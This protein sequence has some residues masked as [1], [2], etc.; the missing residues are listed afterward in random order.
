MRNALFNFYTP[1]GKWEIENQG[2]APDIEVEFDPKAW[3]EGHDPQLEKAVSRLMEE[4]K[5]NSPKPARRP[6]YPNYHNW[7]K[8]P[9]GSGNGS[10]N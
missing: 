10:G 2:V 1:E 6:P 7:I 3:R 8:A 9:A 5:K 4:L